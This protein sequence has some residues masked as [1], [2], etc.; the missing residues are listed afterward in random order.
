MTVH[1]ATT[2]TFQGPAVKIVENHL[3]RAFVKLAQQMVVQ[4]PMTAPGLI[5]ARILPGGMPLAAPKAPS[6]GPPPKP[7]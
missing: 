2:H 4:M 6:A 5:G 3:G 7:V 1:H